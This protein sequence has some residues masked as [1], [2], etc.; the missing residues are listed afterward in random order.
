MH[1]NRK[2]LC[3]VLMTIVLTAAFLTASAHTLWLNATDYTPTWKASTGAKTKIYI[4]WGHHF[5]LD[6]YVNAEDFIKISLVSP[7]LKVKDIALETTGFAAS[8]LG[9]KEKGTYLVG[10]TRKASNN[11]KYQKDGKVVA[12]KGTKEGLEK[13]I[14]STHSQQFAK[15]LLC[16]GAGHSKN[17]GYVFGHKLEIIPLTNPYAL[18][19]NTGGIMKLKVLLNGKPVMY[20]KVYAMYEGYS[21]DDQFASTAS[22]DG[23]GIAE[24]RITHWGPWV[25][26]T[27][28]TGPAAGKLKDKVNEEKYFASLTFF[29]P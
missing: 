17:I 25:V 14:S 11:T 24:L 21:Q 5:P 16:A 26:K 4:G 20:N 10:I 1:L 27:N 9:L 22:T 23:N 7:S 6:G 18:T 19:N 8:S 28:V 15:I 12:I 29:V 13:V 2:T 3:T